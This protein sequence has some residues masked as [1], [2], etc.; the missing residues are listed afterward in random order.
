MKYQCVKCN[1]CCKTK[2]LWEQHI[3]TL[4][5][6]NNYNLSIPINSNVCEYC[7]KVYKSRS[8]LWKH[9]KICKK[10]KLAIEKNNDEIILNMMN[11]IKEQNKIITDMIPKIGNNQINNQINNQFNINVFLNEKCNEAI[12]MSDFINSI[13]IQ[14]K[15]LIYT[16]NNGLLQGISTVF[17]NELKQ[18]DTYK[19]PIHCSDVKRETI[20]IKDNNAWDKDNSKIKIHNAINDIANKQ[21]KAISKWEHDNPNWNITDKGKDDYI[22]LMKSIMSDI[23]KEENKIVKTIAK[24][25]IINK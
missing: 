25:T 18:L 20:Y 14:C 1:Y 19:R 12:N 5:H 21:R 22:K 11:Q 6:I 9:N 17:M 7:N 24:E 23:S 10:K 13:N 2:S 4:K 16:K 3:S 15:D 8:G